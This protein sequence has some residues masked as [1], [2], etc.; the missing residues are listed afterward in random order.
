MFR[1]L[2]WQCIGKANY[3][4]FYRLLVW[5]CLMEIMHLATQLYLIIDIFLKGPANQRTKNSFIQS[6]TAANAIFICFCVFNAVSIILIGQLIAF[7]RKLQ[8]QRLSTYE[9]IVQDHKRRRELARREGD[10]EAERVLLVHKAEAERATL[11]KWKLQCGGLCRQVGCAACDPLDLP[12]PPAEPDP[13]AGFARALGGAAGIMGATEEEQQQ[14]GTN[15]D[16]NNDED[17]DSETAT[18]AA[19]ETTMNGHDNHHNHEPAQQENGT[20]TEDSQHSASSEPAAATTMNGDDDDAVEHS[21]HSADGTNRNRN[22]S[23]HHSGG[24]D[25]LV[26]QQE[27]LLDDAYQAA[28][29]TAEAQHS[30]SSSLHHHHQQQQQPEEISS[31]MESIE[32]DIHG[33]LLQL[34]TPLDDN[35]DNDNNMEDD[36]IPETFQDEPEEG[37]D[38]VSV[39]S[40]CSGRSRRSSKSGRSKGSSTASNKKGRQANG[41]RDYTAF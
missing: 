21:N 1:F 15:D 38:N 16:N 27:K 2:T 41:E 5:L 32:Y 23:S 31:P 12:E 30:S 7:H 36:N 9:F 19:A 8:R 13:E 40:G 4:S 28:A 34:S 37:D 18:A 35:D 39:E 20:A 26:E 11:Q 22:E 17:N 10:L 6:T 3:Q 33:G 29:A 14:H 25:M 24:D